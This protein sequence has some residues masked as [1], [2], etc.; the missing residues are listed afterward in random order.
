MRSVRTPVKGPFFKTTPTPP[1]PV[2]VEAYAIVGAFVQAY[3]GHYGTP[4][5]MR[6]DASEYL[7]Q[8]NKDRV[9]SVL[10]KGLSA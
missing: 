1:D 2:S 7:Y 3:R 4:A 6:T 5:R 10:T 8:A 9:L